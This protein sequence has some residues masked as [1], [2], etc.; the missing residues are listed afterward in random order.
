MIGC[1]DDESHNDI[2]II[3]EQHA[4]YTLTQGKWEEMP[5][6]FQELGIICMNS[7]P[8]IHST[9]IRDKHAP[10]MEL[11]NTRHM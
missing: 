5:S 10:T 11:L 8:S 2:V 9:N 6:Y 7:I 4:K 1:K 3:R